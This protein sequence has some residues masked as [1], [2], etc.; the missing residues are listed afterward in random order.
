MVRMMAAL[1]VGCGV[2]AMVVGTEWV[3]A[4]GMSDVKMLRGMRS[5]RCVPQRVGLELC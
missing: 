1:W 5:R 3:V 4:V 2:L